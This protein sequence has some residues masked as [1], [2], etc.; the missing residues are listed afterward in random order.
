MLKL[1][2]ALLNQ[3]I[4][5]LRTGGIIGTT[6][7]AIINPNN[8]KIEG[9]YCTDAFSKQQVI[10]LTQDVRDTAK[11][12]LIVNDHDV[13]TQPDE[14]IRLQD[15]LKL[16]FELIGKHVQTT[17]KQR[18]GKVHDFAVD[19]QTLYVQKLYVSQS[20]VKSF[21]SRELTIDRDQIVEI[22]NRR[23]IIKELEK[24]TKNTVPAVAPAL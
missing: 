1:S 23:I 21:S 24:P 9:F 4:M 10:L 3:P 22:T 19:N 14:L 2:A 13:L 6:E 11:Q 18:V 7:T 5:S 12:G 8:L 15:V 17:T 20:L 16:K